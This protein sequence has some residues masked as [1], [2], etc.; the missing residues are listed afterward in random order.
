MKKKGKRK[1]SNELR[2]RI[3]LEVLRKTKTV[4]QLAQQYDIHPSQ[5]MQWK[6]SF[7]ENAEFIIGERRPEVPVIPG[8]RFSSFALVDKEQVELML[9]YRNL[10]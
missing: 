3:I 6:K 9:M 10:L 7:E 2:D 8:Q 4:Q 5:I 1:V